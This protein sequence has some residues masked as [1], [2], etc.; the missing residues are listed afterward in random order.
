MGE[1]ESIAYFGLQREFL[2]TNL[3]PL[4]NY[5][6]SLEACNSRGCGRSSKVSFLTG[7]MAPLSVSLPIIVNITE[8]SIVLKWNKP[9]NDQIYSGFLIGYVLYVSHYHDFVFNTSVYN[10][11]ACTDCSSNV[12]LLSDLT[13]GVDYI[14]VLSAC[15]SGGCTNSSELRVSTLESFPNVD[16]IV[17]RAK[18]KTATSLLVAW[19][20]PSRPNGKKIVY[21]SHCIA[22]KYHSVYSIQISTVSSR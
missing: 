18:E 4:S 3:K 9:N 13:P 15:T 17:I 2:V 16:D 19:N 5:T 8:E 7:E 1:T 14:I 10:A 20:E 21:F 12:Q 11:S 22:W 6:F